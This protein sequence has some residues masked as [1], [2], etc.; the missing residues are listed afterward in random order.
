VYL[1]IENRYGASNIDRSSDEE[2]VKK[3]DMK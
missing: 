3:D 2:E 1:F